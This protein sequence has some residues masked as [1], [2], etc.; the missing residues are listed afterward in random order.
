[1]KKIV[2][3]LMIMLPVSLLTFSQGGNNSGQNRNTTRQEGNSPGQSEKTRIFTIFTSSGCGCTGSGGA[4]WTFTTH[5]MVLANLQRECPDIDFVNWEG[6]YEDAVREV[7]TNTESYDGVL[8]VGRIDWDYRLA[9]TGL[10]TIVVYNLFEFMD[11]QPYHL[12]ETGETDQE[13]SV[14]KGGRDYPETRILTATLDRRNVC[15]PSVTEAMFDDLV[16]KIRLIRAI[17]ELGQ[18]RILMVKRDS[19]EVIASVNYRGD[20]NQ[21]FPPD[22][23]SRTTAQLKELFGAEIVPVEAEEF[24]ETYA[25]TDI[26]SAEEVAGKW[27]D[28]AR[29]VEASREE[30]VK[31]ARAYLAFDELREKYDCNAVSTHIRRVAGSGKLEHRFWPGLGLELGFKTRGIQAVCQNYPDML[32]AEIM[33]YLLTGRPSMLGDYMYDTFNSTEILLHCGIPVNPYGDERRLPYTIRTHAESPVRDIPSEPGSSTGI[34]TEWPAGEIV[35][36]WEV[37]SLT[38]EIRLHTGTL[39]DG[40]VVYSGGEELENVMCTAKIIARVENIEKIRDQFRPYLYGIHRIAT[41][42]D[43]RQQIKDLGKLIG[44][45]VIEMD[46]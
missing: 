27:I 18:T 31:T 39:V 25:N 14:L 38:R 26:R 3:F 29:E 15:A 33:G 16:Y 12:F 5:E 23:N 4:P 37:H 1:M 8:I 43:L 19:G 21:Y 32:I 30:V 13:R 42:G 24:F 35:T 20:Y 28:D 46:R 36:F 2:V 9:F 40:N 7:E 11:A 34:T 45:R 6:A 17:Q 44:F 10:P 41:L 22:H